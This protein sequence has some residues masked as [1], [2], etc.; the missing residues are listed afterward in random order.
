MNRRFF[1]RRALELLHEESLAEHGGRPGLRDDGL[2]ESALA[3]P[4][5]LLA[6][7]QSDLASL[8]AAYCFGLIRKLALL[9]GNKRAAFLA[10]GL[11]LAL[12]GHRLQASQ[13]QAT[14]TMLA[15]SAGHLSEGEFAH[16]L[17]E[18]LQAR[19]R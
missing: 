18:H 4:H 13:S 2:L 6:D 8:A 7:G 3:R 14:M 17:S 1:S 11:F 10:V 5:Q 19:T 9:D 16:W 15:L 12:N